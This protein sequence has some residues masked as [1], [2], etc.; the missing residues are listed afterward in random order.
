MPAI[1]AAARHISAGNAGL[2]ETLSYG[3][4]LVVERGITTTAEV[5]ADPATK[6]K[7][8]LK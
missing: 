4:T 2:T 8:L 1:A 7:A 5:L 3:V 6:L